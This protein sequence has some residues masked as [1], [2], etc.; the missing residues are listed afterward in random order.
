MLFSR[1]L[2]GIPPLIRLL[3]RRNEDIHRGAA[4]TLRN[5]SFSA[6]ND[7]NKVAIVIVLS[8][9]IRS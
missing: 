4:G 6:I 8:K 1:A 7:E 9:P 2:N 5:L 3:D